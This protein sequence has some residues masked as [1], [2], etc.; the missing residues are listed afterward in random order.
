[1]TSADKVYGCFDNEFVISEVNSNI[2]IWLKDAT[3]TSGWK[4]QGDYETDPWADPYN[5]VGL[6]I[7]TKKRGAISKQCLCGETDKPTTECPQGAASKDCSKDLV[8]PLYA[9]VLKALLPHAF[10]LWGSFSYQVCSSV[11]ISYTIGSVVQTDEV[12]PI[13]N[14]FEQH[15]QSLMGSNNTSNH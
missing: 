13:T 2:H 14:G 11:Q 6:Q 1:M 4:Y 10:F 15:F 12:V 7:S 8:R 9:A 3:K 5:T